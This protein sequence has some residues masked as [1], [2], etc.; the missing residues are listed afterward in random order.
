MEGHI[1]L[2]K[3]GKVTKDAIH[4]QSTVTQGRRHWRL[5]KTK[6]A[7]NQA[8][9]VIPTQCRHY[10]RREDRKIYPRGLQLGQGE[11]GQGDYLG[12][13]ASGRR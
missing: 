13:R 2:M 8:I 9:R 6:I 12:N 1:L 3:Y 5:V 4:S 10:W 7:N 11:A